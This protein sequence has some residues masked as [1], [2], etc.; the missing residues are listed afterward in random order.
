MNISEVEYPDRKE[1]Y[2]NV[3]SD[4]EESLHNSVNNAIKKLNVTP[5]NQFI[6]GG[7]GDRSEANDLTLPMTWLT[8][9]RN[10]SNGMI[11]S[12]VTAIKSSSTQPIYQNGRLIGSYYEDEYAKYVR[13][14]GILPDDVNASRE[15]QTTSLLEN[16]NSVLHQND[17]SFRDV[18]RTWFYLDD[19][20]EWYDLFNVCR[21]DFFEKE[22]IFDNL[23]PASTGIGSGNSHGAEIIGDLIAIVP[24]TNAVKI[25]KAK[26]PMQG[27]ALDYRSSFSRGI[28][29][30]FPS[31]NLLYI[32]GTASIDQSGETVYLNNLEKQ[33]KMTMEVVTEM[34]NSA[35]MDWNN[36]KR[37]IAYFKNYE[38]IE[39][40]LTYSEKNDID[41]SSISIFIADVCRDNLLFE[42][43]VDAIKEA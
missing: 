39:E 31:H 16:M 22:K 2:I 5:L 12:Q 3:N 1:Y 18:I 24:K 6:L 4:S 15:V 26:S 40:F 35:N 38:F 8:G 32:S 9:N 21:T 7:K 11:S 14:A 30:K 19:L 25:S 17:M 27:S 34:L 42:I 10:F 36:V 13:L 28:E 43:E 23:V 41:L 37:G 20:L 29:L 33:V